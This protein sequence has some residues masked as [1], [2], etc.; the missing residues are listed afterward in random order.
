MK[1]SK[2]IKKVFN[3]IEDNNKEKDLFNAFKFLKLNNVKGSYVEFGVASGKTLNY[4]YDITKRSDYNF[5]EYIGF[6][7]FEGMPEPKGIDKQFYWNKGDYKHSLTEIK[8]ILSHIKKLKLIK[9]YYEKTLKK[10]KLKD[11]ASYVHIDCDYYHS[12]KLALNFILPYLQNGTIICFDDWYCFYNDENL[13]EQKAF[14]EFK[15]NNKNIIFTELS[16]QELNKM[17]IVRFK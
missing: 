12:S 1:K 3:F 6:D 10:T 17:F 15:E 5:N 2:I 16:S 14:N 9:G 4:A 13:G 7:S 11:K 8:N